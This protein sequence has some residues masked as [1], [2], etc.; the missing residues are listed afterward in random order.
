MFDNTRIIKIAKSTNKSEIAKIRQVLKNA[1]WPDNEINDA[2]KQ[3]KENIKKAKESSQK[4]STTK[5]NNRSYNKWIKD[6]ASNGGSK[7][8][9]EMA[10]N[11]KSENGLIDYGKKQ[12]KQ[13]GGTE[14]PLERIQWDIE[15]I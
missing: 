9:D 3:A 6:V 8:A 1:E 11:A 2:V 10:N 13:Q 12:I 5:W 7:H 14:T 15:T 4:K